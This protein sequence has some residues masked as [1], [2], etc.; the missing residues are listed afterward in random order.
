M[1][2]HVSSQRGRTW[3]APARPYRP[4]SSKLPLVDKDQRTWWQR[5]WGR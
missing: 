4:Q 3:Y 5:I 2:I 1:S